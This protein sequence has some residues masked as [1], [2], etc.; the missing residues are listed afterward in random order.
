M[1]DLDRIGKEAA[2]T[3]AIEAYAADTAE[4]G[5]GVRLEA[6]TSAAAYAL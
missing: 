1:T 2:V 5:T 6:A 3:R 4:A